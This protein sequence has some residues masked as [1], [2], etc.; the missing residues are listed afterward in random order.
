MAATLDPVEYSYA[1]VCIH[2]RNDTYYLPFAALENSGTIDGNSSFFYRLIAAPPLEINNVFGSFCWMHESH[3]GSGHTADVYLNVDPEAL[4]II[5]NYV[6]R[7]LLPA[8]FSPSSLTHV[9]DLATIMGM[10]VLVASLRRIAAIQASSDD[11]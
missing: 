5:N 8:E 10:P 1:M 3:R 6:Q 4:N 9:I 11:Y 7:N 2:N